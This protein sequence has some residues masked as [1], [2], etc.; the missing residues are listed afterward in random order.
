MSTHCFRAMGC[1]VVVG[2]ATGVEEAAVERLFEALEASLSRFRPDSDL[3]RLNRSPAEAVIVSPL[4]AT[5][6]DDALGAAAATAGACDPTIAAALDAAGYDRTFEEI[7]E[8]GRSHRPSRCRPAAGG[9]SASPGSSSAGP[10]GLRLD[11]N[12]VVK[13]RAVDDALALLEGD[14]ASSRPAATSQRAASSSSRCPAATPS[15]SARA[16]SRRAAITT[17]SWQR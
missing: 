11:L 12:G 10:A 14:R 2:G 1:E 13:G 4:L 7:Q 6:I 9:R 16:R 5:A 17:R 3:E 15:P 8:I